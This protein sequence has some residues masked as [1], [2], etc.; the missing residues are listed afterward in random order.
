MD[1]RGPIGGEGSRSVAAERLPLGKRIGWAGRVVQPMA[2]ADCEDGGPIFG[3]WA[4]VLDRELLVS[5]LAR[6]EM[7]IVNDSTTWEG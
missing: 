7:Q 2:G 5:R 3:S 4:P 6:F 1:G